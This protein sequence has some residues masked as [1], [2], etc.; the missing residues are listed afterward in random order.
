MNRLIFLFAA[1]I[2]AIKPFAQNMP[3]G[4]PLDIIPLPQHM[5]TLDGHFTLPD[6]GISFSIDGSDGDILSNYIASLPVK[7]LPADMHKADMHIEITDSKTPANEES[8]TLTIDRNQINITAPTETGAFYAIQSLLQMTRGGILKQLE[9]CTI[10]DTP[11]LAYRGL[12]VDV[13]RHFRPKEFI[14]KQLDAMA[15]LKL[16]SMHLHLTDGAG[17]RLQIDQYPELTS[18]AAWRPYKHW[19]DWWNGDRSYCNIDDPRAYGGFYTKDDIREIVKYAAERHI[20]IIPEIEMP[21]HSEE[22]LAT[23]PELS[24]SGKPYTD[25]DFCIGKEETFTFIEN[26]LSEVME[27]FPSQYIHIGGDEAAKTGWEN[28]PMCRKRMEQENLANLDELQSY[29]IHRI[30]KFVTSK[31]RTVIGFDE[32]MQGGLAPKAVVMSW[33]GI[34]PGYKAMQ[35]GNHAIM[36]PNSHCYLDYTQDAPF[37][38]PVSIGGYIPLEKTYSFEPLPDEATPDE[39]KFLLGVQGNLWAEYI[40][41]DSHAEYMYY[42]RAFAIA[43]IGWTMP[44]RKNYADF[45]RRSLSLI[46]QLRSAGYATFDLAN[47]YGDRKESQQPLSHMGRGCKVIYNTPYSKQY[48]A[49]GDSALTDGVCGGWT[50]G[51]NKWQGTMRDFDVTIDLGGVKPVRYVG[52]TFLQSVGAWVYMPRRVDIYLSDDGEKFTLAGQAWCDVPDTSAEIRYKVYSTLCHSQARYVRIH[53]IKYPK[54]G[55]WLFTDE[56]VIN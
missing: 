13:S 6:G 10:N 15:L 47:E 48:P 50:Y 51:D 27:M 35:Q 31:G 19:E 34:E 18:L 42:P 2:Y 21:G 44:E 16:N 23:Y 46:E 30:E 39:A 45:R 24:C 7:F 33:R 53:A 32:I 55:S 43:E 54:P 8:Y 12:H 37:K 20:D 1:F 26:V 41:D 22:V 38:E 29:M 17:W 40:T 49:A 4:S 14:L 52:A 5:E 3:A 11:R 36:T 28:C 56:I 9:C 25:S